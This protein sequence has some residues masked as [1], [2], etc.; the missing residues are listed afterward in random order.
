MYNI[1]III[2]AYMDQFREKLY[3]VTL[4][5][6]KETF[7]IKGVD[8]GVQGSSVRVNYGVVT[9]CVFRGVPV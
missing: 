1:I 6:N 5:Y 7:R 2:T 8:I 4:H 9:W 3:V